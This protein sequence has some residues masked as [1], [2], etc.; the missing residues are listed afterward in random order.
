[1][2]S[3]KNKK[4]FTL[5]ELM[6]VIVILG[7]LAILAIPKFT[8]ATA[9]AKM[10]EIPGVLASYEHAQLAYIAETGGAGD[11]D[12]LAFDADVDSKWFTY[13]G[14]QSG[15]SFEAQADATVGDF[16]QN[17]YVRTKYDAGN[18]E[19][20]HTSDDTDAKK[21]LPTFID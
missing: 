5:I 12:N 16:D 9:K 1:M 18:D 17:K 10:S 3:L 2:R 6:V 4:G 7:I 14:D 11:Y 19:F 15:N 20:D 21:Y 13:K 8:A